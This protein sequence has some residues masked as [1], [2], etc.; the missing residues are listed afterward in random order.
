MSGTIDQAISSGYNLQQSSA[1]TPMATSS[2]V[3][4]DVYNNVSTDAEYRLRGFAAM[5]PEEQRR[6]ARMGGVQR[7]KQL[8][9]QA[10][11]RRRS[12]SPSGKG[13]P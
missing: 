3:S 12:S 2:D 6:I 4:N 9:E 8:H 10:V 13:S 11:E 7:G 5:D 1:P